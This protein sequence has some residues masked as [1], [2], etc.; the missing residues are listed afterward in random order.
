MGRFPIYAPDYRLKIGGDN[1]P[2]AL[3]A[4]IVS[5]NY[6]DGM[7]GADRVEVTIANEDLRWLDHPLLQVDNG[8]KLSL[9]YAPDPLEEVFVGEIT[10]VEPTFPNSG[11]PTIKI[12][13]HDFL[14]RLTKG[15]KDRGFV[16]NIPSIGVRALP[17]PVIAALISAE[18]LLI[19]TTVPI[20]GV[21]SVL[22]TDNTPPIG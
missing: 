12:V 2:A 15:K 10:G 3:R 17:D 1:I 22:L 4:A 20:G 9:G 11:M 14:Q 6:Q 21:L 5:I 18:N 19:P 7:E 13:A 16:L 8:F